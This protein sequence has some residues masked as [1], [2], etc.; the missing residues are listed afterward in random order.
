M[1]VASATPISSH[2]KDTAR[3]EEMIFFVKGKSWYFITIYIIKTARNNRMDTVIR[4]Q[5]VLYL[6]IMTFFTKRF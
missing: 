2:V 4:S 6:F 3:D 5:I 1:L